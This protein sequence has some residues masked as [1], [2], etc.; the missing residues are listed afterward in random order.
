MEATIQLRMV[1]R[2]PLAP[3]NTQVY[4]RDVM[5]DQLSAQDWLDRGLRALAAKGAGALKA[6]S[7]AKAMGVSRG[8]F[9]WHFADIAAF[10]TAIL[11]Q[12]R[13]VSAERVIADLEIAAEHENPLLLLLRRTF[14]GTSENSVFTRRAKR[15]GRVSVTPPLVGRGNSRSLRSQSGKKNTGIF[16]VGP[17]KKLI[18]RFANEMIGAQYSPNAMVAQASTPISP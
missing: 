4:G 10:R 11:A 7:L 16:Q 3:V 2:P 1:L 13:E 9:Y 15:V 8:S 12:W 17:V 14:F 6:E 5:S 18:D